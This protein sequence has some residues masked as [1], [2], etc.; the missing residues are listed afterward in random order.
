MLGNGLQL[1]G[2]KLSIAWEKVVDRLTRSYIDDIM[3]R[4]KN[5]GYPFH[6]QDILSRFVRTLTRCF[7]LLFNPF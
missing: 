4:I 5:L 6:H 2:K 7:T 3:F 1:L